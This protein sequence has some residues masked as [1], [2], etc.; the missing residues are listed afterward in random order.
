LCRRSRNCERRGLLC[1]IAKAGRALEQA[2]REHETKVQEIEKD[3]AALDK[4]SEVE[5]AR[6]EKQKE[7]LET[8]LRRASN[9][10]GIDAV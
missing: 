10:I 2:K 1:P 6:W 7:K 4:R 5:N 9:E 3:R 8:A